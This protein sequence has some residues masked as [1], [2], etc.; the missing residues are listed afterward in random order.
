M[1]RIF[2]WCIGQADVSL[3]T[4]AVGFLFFVFVWYGGDWGGLPNQAFFGGMEQLDLRLL[5][6]PLNSFNRGDPSQSP[7]FFALK[8]LPF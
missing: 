2:T 3:S 7:C 6:I 1:T 5:G 8:E 4:P